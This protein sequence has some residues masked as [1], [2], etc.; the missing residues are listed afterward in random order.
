M[1]RDRLVFTSDLE[2][3]SATAEKILSFRSLPVGW[4]YG[5]GGPL[6]VDVVNRALQIDSYYRQLGF[7]TTDAFPGADGELM[8]TAYRGPHC[9]ETIISTDLRYSVT[10]ERDDT[11]ISA[12]SDLD[13]R[14]AKQTIRRIGAEIWC[15]FGLSIQSTTTKRGKG[16][17]ASRSKTQ[18]VAEFPSFCESVW[19]P[20]RSPFADIS[21]HT[22]PILLENLQ[23]TGNFPKLTFQSKAA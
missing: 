9:I 22:T 3:V 8:I 20:Q 23:S 1:N 13:D 18:P 4:H 12:I 19:R 7:S 10:H 2:F 16:S 14:A 11:E 17:E 5:R 15:S 21:E 6:S